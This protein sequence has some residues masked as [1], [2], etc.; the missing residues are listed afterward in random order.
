MN[1][2]TCLLTLV[3]WK[4]RNKI[5]R[6]FASMC[7]C[8][9]AYIF[10]LRI[11]SKERNLLKIPYDYNKFREYTNELKNFNKKNN[12]RASAAVEQHSHTPINYS[13]SFKHTFSSCNLYEPKL[14][15]HFK[16]AYTRRGL[17]LGLAGKLNQIDLFHASLHKQHV[18]ST[19]F[20]FF[21]KVQPM[22]TWM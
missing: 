21:V 15:C 6:S 11:L 1:L 3:N 13:P 22:C 2:L 18:K 20:F 8:M 14:T 5:N 10:P 9:L 19:P 17:L 16:W 4:S 12:T 7:L